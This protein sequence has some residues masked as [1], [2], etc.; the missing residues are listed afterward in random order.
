[1]FF[2]RIHWSYHY[3]HW[4]VYIYSA[5]NDNNR[6]CFTANWMMWQEQERFTGNPAVQKGGVSVIQ[7]WRIIAITWWNE[8]DEEVPPVLMERR[9]RL[10]YNCST[11]TSHIHQVISISTINIPNATVASNAV[12][13]KVLKL[14]FM[15]PNVHTNSVKWSNLELPPSSV[16]TRTILI[17]KINFLPLLLIMLPLQWEWLSPCSVRPHS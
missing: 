15:Y 14:S 12:Y 6:Q 3:R 9:I 17:T 2:L 4:F 1:M 8:G 11:G 5:T 7:N 16:L 13:P 10:P